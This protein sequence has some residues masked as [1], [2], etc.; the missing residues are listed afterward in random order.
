MTF[1]FE[2]FVDN[3]KK[4]VRFYQKMFGFEVVKSQ[5]RYAEIKKGDVRI[6]IGSAGELMKNHHFNPEIQNQRKGL[7]VEIV[8]EVNDIDKVYKCI[9][10]KGYP[11]ETKMK[12]REWGKKD[13]RVADPDGYYIRVTTK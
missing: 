13:F 8:F 3:P 9:Q 5:A 4:T 10:D 11:T 12:M 7:G 2:L 1:K 6:G